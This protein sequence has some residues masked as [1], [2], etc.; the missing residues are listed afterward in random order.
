MLLESDP[1]NPCIFEL[2]PLC[3]LLSASIILCYE[4]SIHFELMLSDCGFILL[5]IDKQCLQ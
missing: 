1:E 2:S 5:H 3:F 4:S